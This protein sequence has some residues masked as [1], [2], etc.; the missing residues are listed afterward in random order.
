MPTPTQKADLARLAKI[1]E[2]LSE[3]KRLA[4]ELSSPRQRDPGMAVLHFT[5]EHA[6]RIATERHATEH[7]SLYDALPE[8]YQRTE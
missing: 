8:S 7:V 5:L 3:A 6:A 1:A 2:L 4:G